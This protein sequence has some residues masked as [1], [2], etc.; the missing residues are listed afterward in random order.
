MLL[1]SWLDLGGLGW[2]SVV[3][4]SSI[5][6]PIAGLFTPLCH[7]FETALVADLCLRSHLAPRGGTRHG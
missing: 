2:S 6:S 1:W 7:C 5:R 3:G 4:D